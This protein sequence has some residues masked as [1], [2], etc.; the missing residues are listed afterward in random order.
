MKSIKNIYNAVAG[1]CLIG[2]TAAAAVMGMASCTDIDENGHVY[3]AVYA[4]I[5]SD[6]LNSDEFGRRV[7]DMRINYVSEV[8]NGETIDLY[9]ADRDDSIIVVG[10]TGD[11]ISFE[12]E[13][14]DNEQYITDII[15]KVNNA[16]AVKE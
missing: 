14:I 8:R 12:F 6:I 3:N 1:K 2:I 16:P 4:D 10:K 13:L 5:A 15:P 9:R 7:T 11:K